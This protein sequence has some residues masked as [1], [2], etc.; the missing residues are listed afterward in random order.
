M[1]RI[2]RSF[3]RL[4]PGVGAMV[5][6]AAGLG[7]AFNALNPH[8]LPLVRKPL[9]ETRRFVSTSEL[10][11]KTPTH[12]APAD[13]PQAI[14][15]MP[16]SADTPM[17]ATTPQ[18]PVAVSVPST[19]PPKPT[20]PV[21]VPVNM[22]VASKPEAAK[23]PQPRVEQ[24]SEQ[25]AKQPEALFTNLKDAKALFDKKSAIFLD[26]RM[27][28]DFEAEHIPGSR[29]LFCEKVD[30]L[31]Q[32]LLAGVPKDRIIVT[33]CSDPECSEAIDLADALVAKGYTKV[34][35]LLEGLPGWKDAG[36][37]T[38]QGKEPG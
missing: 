36:Y 12:F 32:K 2:T 18:E 23:K 7:L 37:S 26:A 5:V 11:A 29:S 38:T 6:L 14:R 35:I 17:P 3:V 19:I 10:F 20:P 30:D 13:R 24:T 25:P 15:P 8:G 4:I 31:Y 33:Y 21:T 22:S 34:V 28:E 27:P 16:K 1:N 9:R